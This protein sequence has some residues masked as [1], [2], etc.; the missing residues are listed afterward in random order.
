MTGSR[1]ARFVFLAMVSTAGLAGPMAICA[2]T[3][4]YADP[5]VSDLAVRAAKLA[6][7]GQF[8][9][10]SSAAKQSRDDAAIKLVELIYLRDHPNEA[11]YARIMDFLNVAP[12]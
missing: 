1:L 11:G 7:A 6:L 9:D 10:A 8:D 3:P 4:A 12:N 2:Q 5:Q